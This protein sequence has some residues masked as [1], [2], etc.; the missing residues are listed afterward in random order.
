MTRSIV[1][2]L[3]AILVVAGS[4][5][6]LAACVSGTPATY[7]DISAIMFER[8]GCGEM[9]PPELGQNPSIDCSHYWVFFGND[10]PGGTYSQSSK[11]VDFGTYHIDATI[12]QAI[13]VLRKDDFYLLGPG[14]AYIT[15]I[16]ETVL[17]V[18]HCGVVTRVMMYSNG[19]DAKTLELF[20]DL[21][22]LV[23]DAKKKQTLDLP[24]DFPYRSLFD[25]N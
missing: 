6:S 20:Y 22:K 12:S 4:S 16:R 21:E 9:R 10:E 5:A 8:R 17:T 23:T 14:D 19:K 1:F 15:D 3:I 7:N 11:R 18:R 13:D 2:V 25:G 24:S